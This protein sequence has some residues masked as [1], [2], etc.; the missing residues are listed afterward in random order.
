VLFIVFEGPEKTRVN[1]WT[2]SR[3]TPKPAQ[4]QSMPFLYSFE[5]FSGSQRQEWSTTLLTISFHKNIETKDTS[6]LRWQI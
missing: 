3:P 6:L 5:N 1:K 2:D 4:E